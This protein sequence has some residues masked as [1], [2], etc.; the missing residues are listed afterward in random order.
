MRAGEIV[1]HK[2][3]DR[4]VDGR[5]HR[6]DGTWVRLLAITP[7]MCAVWVIEPFLVMPSADFI[8]W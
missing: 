2:N 3:E 4:R 7:A 8:T 1:C 5:A 6:V